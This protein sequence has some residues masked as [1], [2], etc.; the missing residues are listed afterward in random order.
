[1][2]AVETV[3]AQAAHQDQKV[4]PRDLPHFLRPVGDRCQRVRTALPLKCG[5]TRVPL[6]V[7]PSDSSGSGFARKLDPESLLDLPTSGLNLSR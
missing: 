3:S 4:L 5:A 1:M 2:I 7:L 6:F